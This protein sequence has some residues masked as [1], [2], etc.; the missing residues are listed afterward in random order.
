M[1]FS[2][3][4]GAK[5]REVLDELPLEEYGQYIK[6]IPANAKHGDQFKAIWEFKVRKIRAKPAATA[7]EPTEESTG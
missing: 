5:D 7:P 4:K 2:A 6:G 1:V 3:K